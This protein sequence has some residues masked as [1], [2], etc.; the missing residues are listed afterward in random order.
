MAKVLFTNELQQ[1]TDGVT[2]AEVAARD[3]RDLVRELSDRFPALSSEFLQQQA[4][5]IDGTVISQPLLESF[6]DNSE[7]VFLARLQ[8]G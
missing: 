6:E 1:Y 8:G 7:L 4:L 2:E 5:S 3:Y